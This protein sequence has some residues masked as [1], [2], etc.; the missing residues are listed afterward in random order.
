MTAR[1][2]AICKDVILSEERVNVTAASSKSRIEWR[3]KASKG[4]EGG[5]ISFSDTSLSCGV[6]EH[7]EAYKERPTRE[8]K[9]GPATVSTGNPAL[10][11]SVAVE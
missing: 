6:S 3:T 7:K 4:H 1:A 11:A 2:R 5:E 8:G 9:A 10:R